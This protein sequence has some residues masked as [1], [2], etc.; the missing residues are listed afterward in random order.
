MDTLWV[1]TTPP[2][3]RLVFVGLQLLAKRTQPAVRPAIEAGLLFSYLLSLT[4]LLLSISP[5][6]DSS[7]PLLSSFV[8]VAYVPLA[9]VAAVPPLPSLV[10]RRLCRKSLSPAAP[11]A[12]VILDTTVDHVLLFDSL[13]YP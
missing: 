12:S 9:V 3:S 7:M 4:L 5:C 8:F 6:L 2:Q 11:A 1:R 13:S 10:P